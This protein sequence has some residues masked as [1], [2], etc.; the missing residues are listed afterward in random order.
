VIRYNDKNMSIFDLDSYTIYAITNLLDIRSLY[1]FSRTCQKFKDV[2]HEI[3][4]K[5]A[6]QKQVYGLFAK[7]VLDSVDV[8]GTGTTDGN[9]ILIEACLNVIQYTYEVQE[10]IISRLDVNIKHSNEVIELMLGLSEV[11]LNRNYDENCVLF[12]EGTV[13]NL[14]TD[15]LLDDPT[16]EDDED[17][18]VDYD[19]IP[20]FNCMKVD[21]LKLEYLHDSDNKIR[22]KNSLYYKIFKEFDMKLFLQDEEFQDLC[23]EIR[24]TTKLD[25]VPDTIIAIAFQILFGPT[26]KKISYHNKESVRTMTTEELHLLKNQVFTLR[27][28]N[29]KHILSRTDV[30]KLIQY[31]TSLYHFVSKEK[32]KDFMDDLIGFLKTFKKILVKEDSFLKDKEITA[33]LLQSSYIEYGERIMFFKIQVGH[34]KY[35]YNLD[36]SDTKL[37]IVY[38]RDEGEYLYCSV[39]DVI[40]EIEMLEIE[41]PGENNKDIKKVLGFFNNFIDR[42]Y[43]RKEGETV[44]SEQYL[45]SFLNFL[46]EVTE[47][48]SYS[49][50]H[51]YHMSIIN[52]VHTK[53]STK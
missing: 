22:S 51:F 44:I 50:K 32:F 33:F 40:L 3:K 52:N 16:D 25:E 30:S 31:C 23:C 10:N 1:N 12:V 28:N 24:T 48:I 37:D 21:P 4:D 38:W 15:E 46:F 43:K 13:N 29:L 5:R 41:D 42:N 20:G 34:P 19:K 27:N 26:V 11:L 35:Q 6:W 14:L 17:V 49:Y 36:G 2:C 45:V 8:V 39:N 7:T 9:L 53:E 18:Y 47:P